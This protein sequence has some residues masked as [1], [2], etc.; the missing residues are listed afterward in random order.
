M[1]FSS[2]DHLHLTDD[3][4]HSTELGLIILYEEVIQLLQIENGCTCVFVL[5]L[6]FTNLERRFR[7]NIC[8]S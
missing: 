2:C 1:G 7:L 8:N 4:L 3:L 6:M 5:K